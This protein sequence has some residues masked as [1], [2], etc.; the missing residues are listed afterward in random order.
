MNILTAAKLMELYA[1][2]PKCGCEVIGNGKGALECDTS[3]G[4]FRRTCSCG[5]SVEVREN[6][7]EPAPTEEPVPVEKPNLVPE[8]ET[9]LA[10]EPESSEKL[11]EPPADD[12]WKSK[13]ESVH[14]N[15]MEKS[16]IKSWKGF[17]Y[18]RCEACHHEAAI[19]LRSPTTEYRC[20]DCGHL[21]ILPKAYR[22]YT[23]CECG[24]TSRYLT[25]ITDYAF[26]IP[27]VVCGAP[28]AVTY[29]PGKDCYVPASNTPRR[30][31]S[32]KKKK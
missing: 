3:A 2:C 4:T 14:T 29:D 18:I 31:K 21:M 17:V 10:P 1:A 8:E 32:R 9:A 22:A 20:R 6:C 11:E 27:C 23:Q 19:C 16:T 24:K 13:S 15:K 25:N 5:W 7:V 30:T 28:Q 26:D 12:L